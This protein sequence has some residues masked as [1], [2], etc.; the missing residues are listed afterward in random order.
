MKKWICLAL[1]VLLL[2]TLAL[3]VCA[4][5]VGETQ[6]SHTW[7]GGMVTI[8]ATCVAAGVK[9]FTCTGCGTTKTEE[10][11][12][13]GVHSLTGWTSS[14]DGHTRQCWDCSYSES[15][16]HTWDDGGV[17]QVA[18]CSTPGTFVKTCTVCGG[19]T[20][21]ET[22]KDPNNHTFSSWNGSQEGSHIRTC[23]GCGKTESA[24]HSWDAS[25]TVPATCASEGATAYGC[26]TC[27]RIEYEI[28]PKT[29]THTYDNVCDPDCNICGAT[30]DVKHNFSAT[31]S[32]NASGHWHACTK[33]GEKKDMGNH[34]PGPAATEEEAQICLT[35][36]YTMTARLNHVHK[37][38][39]T[40]SFDETGHW[41]AC[42]GCDE[43]KDFAEHVYDDACDP[44][45]NLCGYLTDTAHTLDGTW[46][47]DETG[48]WGICTVCGE[49]SK[50]ADH[51]P[52]PEATEDTPQT[53]EICGYEIAPVLEH[54]HEGE[55]EWQTDEESHWQ[56]C[57]CG[58]KTE[59][60]AHVWDEGT[61]NEDT[62]ITYTCTVC[63][64]QRLEGEPK[65]PSSFPWGVVLLIL[66]I[67]ILAAAVALIFLLK[68]KKGKYGK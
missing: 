5:E 39:T 44:D 11:P 43:Q 18:T 52:G 36:G 38:D 9:T 61:E 20:T 46:Q 57:A 48:H 29:T 30:R 17:G 68:P 6:H 63:G 24:P 42:S 67:C 51:V 8:R 54:E 1:T 4:E 15:G 32:K 14:G 27:G 3:P 64:A 59:P 28:L 40:Y 35:C 21:T 23:S 53:C 49:A 22:G 25:A 66:V 34:F 47:S 60:E 56:L 13:T 19:I 58:E 41:Y 7:D 50:K 12:A 45:C 65:Q 10:I 31:W 37:Y 55:G 62:T 16:S 33:C 2:G 26:S